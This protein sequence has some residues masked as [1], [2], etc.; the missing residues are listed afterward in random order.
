MIILKK[1][2]P[3]TIDDFEELVDWGVKFAKKKGITLKDILKD[4][5]V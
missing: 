5:R 1:L 4:D 3:P 2:Q